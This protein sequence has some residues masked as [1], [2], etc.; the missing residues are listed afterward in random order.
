MSGL[1]ALVTKQELE[2]WGIDELL[3]K[4]LPIIFKNNSNNKLGCSSATENNLVAFDIKIIFLVT[5]FDNS[6]FVA[7]FGDKIGHALT[8]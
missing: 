4:I 6:C 8:N 3:V 1:C 5:T 2:Y 7:T